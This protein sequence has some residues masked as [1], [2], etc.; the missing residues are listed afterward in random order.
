MKLLAENP[1]SQTGQHLIAKMGKSY[2]KSENIKGIPDEP[3]ENL[4]RG[5]GENRVA[6]S[7]TGLAREPGHGYPRIC[8]EKSAPLAGLPQASGRG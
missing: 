8:P 4:R 2:P 5:D 6:E 3:V 7:S 1:D